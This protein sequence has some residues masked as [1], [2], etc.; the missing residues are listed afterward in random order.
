[1][2][3]LLH[4]HGDS[5]G[6]RAACLIE[7]QDLASQTEIGIV[8]VRPL[9]ACK[10]IVL[11][12]AFDRTDVEFIDENGGGR[13]CEC[14]GHLEREEQIKATATADSKNIKVWYEIVIEQEPGWGGKESLKR[15]RAIVL[16]TLSMPTR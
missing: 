16:A 10:L 11:K 2:S 1:M 7:P 6:Q 4:G 3:I 8:A 9:E 15:Q 5:A 12:Q 14:N 13:G